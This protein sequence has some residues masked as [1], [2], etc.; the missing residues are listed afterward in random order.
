MSA[1]AGTC[2]QDLMA[3][4][5]YSCNCHD[6]FSLNPKTGRCRAGTLCDNAA[7]DPWP[8]GM[9][10]DTSDC[11]S[12]VVTPCVVGN[13]ESTIASAAASAG[14]PIVDLISIR[15]EVPGACPSLLEVRSDFLAELPQP[16]LAC[17]TKVLG[18]LSVAC[19]GGCA[20]IENG[21]VGP[22]L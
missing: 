19:A 14:C 4:G 18:S 2:V 7:S 16:F 3:T 1:L 12:R 15:V 6:G 10:F 22:I 13:L 8:F 11:G 17:F 5:I 20:L 9:R 21:P